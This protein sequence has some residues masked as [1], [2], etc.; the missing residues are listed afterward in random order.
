[1]RTREMVDLM[2]ARGCPENPDRVERYNTTKMPEGTTVYVVRCQDYGEAHYSDVPP[3]LA[4][5]RAA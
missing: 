3:A 5:R 4:P 1:M 2:H